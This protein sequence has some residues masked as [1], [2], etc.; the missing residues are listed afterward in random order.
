MLI[1]L[2][3]ISAAG[4]T[5]FARKFGEAHHVPEF[6]EN[7]VAPGESDRAEIHAEYWMEHNIRR[8][9]AALAVERDHGFAIFDT[10]PFKSHFDWCMACAGF[11]SF[12]IFDAAVPLAR[13][14]ILERRIGFGDRYYVK[15]IAPDVAR[16]QKEGDETRSRRNF[17]MHLALQPH[18]I[19]WFE[20]LAIALPGRVAFSFPDQDALLAELKSK[21]PEENPR[22]FDVSVLDALVKALP[23]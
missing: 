20:A 23:R 7:G 8:F 11:R 13:K 15:R 16:A 12:D 18:L 9:Q 14:A 6:P 1:V 3:G 17:D 2:E 21:A 4:K 22:R 19:K 10:E 5:T